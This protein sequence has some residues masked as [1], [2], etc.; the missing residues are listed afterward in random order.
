MTGLRCW[1]SLLADVVWPCS[2]IPAVP[3]AAAAD[4]VR[5]LSL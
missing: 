4:S 2:S 1:L 3:T 5:S